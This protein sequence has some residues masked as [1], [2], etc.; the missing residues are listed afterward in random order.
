MKKEK[1]SPDTK[2]EK[3]YADISTAFALFSDANNSE[4]A[5]GCELILLKKKRAK[6][7]RPNNINNNLSEKSVISKWPLRLKA[8]ILHIDTKTAHSLEATIACPAEKSLLLPHTL[9]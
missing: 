8:P 7:V 3:R 4:T 1:Y 5:Q 9:Y 2:K 6:V